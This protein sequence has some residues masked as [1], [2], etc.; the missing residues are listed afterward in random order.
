MA[1]KGA[2]D[3]GSIN[4]APG[5]SLK[6]SVAADVIRVRMSVVYGCK[7]PAVG[8]EMLTYFSSRVFIVPAVYQADV[9]SVQFDKPDLSGA[10][11][12]IAVLSNLNQFEHWRLTS[13]SP[14][15]FLHL[16]CRNIHKDVPLLYS[17]CLMFR[18]NAAFAGITAAAATGACPAFSAVSCKKQRGNE[19]CGNNHQQ[20]KIQKIHPAVLVIL[21]EADERE[22]RRSMQ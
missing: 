15:S 22:M 5:L 11:D 14:S 20:Q 6:I 8:V 13:L 7:I 1:G 10:L 18:G 2:V 16:L 17:I 9:L 12:I 3:S 4:A 19:N 21:S